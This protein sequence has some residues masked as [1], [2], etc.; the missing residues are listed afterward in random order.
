MAKID[1]R[2]FVVIADDT[3]CPMKREVVF[4][5]EEEIE[6][7]RYIDEFIDKTFDENLNL[8]TGTR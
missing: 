2:D 8:K 3:R 6:H 7:N 4:T 5:E 1:P